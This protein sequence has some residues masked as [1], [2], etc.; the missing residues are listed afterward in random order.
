MEQPAEVQTGYT[1]Y[2]IKE[3]LENR[4]EQLLKIM[5][6]NH[7][8]E[9]LMSKVENGDADLKALLEDIFAI[10]YRNFDF[11][12]SE[13]E[14]HMN[15]PK[16]KLILKE[17]WHGVRK[18]KGS[19]SILED[20]NYD[21]FEKYLNSFMDIAN[22][23]KNI[24]SNWGKNLNEVQYKIPC[25]NVFLPVYPYHFQK[26]TFSFYP[27]YPST[28]TMSYVTKNGTAKKE[29]D[30]DELLKSFFISTEMIP[31]ELKE[32]LG[33]SQSI[34]SSVKEDDYQETHCY[35]YVKK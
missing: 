24:I 18:L 31:Q 19:T 34:D 23:Y 5:D 22:S 14:I 17:Y 32:L 26:V 35:C 33:Y 8:R 15:H 29:I 3:A 1:L 10:R 28:V 11:E 16:T 12:E 2:E 21:F 9:F 27:F 6:V 20:E 30:N 7:V 13:I 4:M 25:Y